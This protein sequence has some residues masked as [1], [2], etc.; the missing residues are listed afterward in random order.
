MSQRLNLHEVSREPADSVHS[1]LT[2]ACNSTCLSKNY[3]PQ[4]FT[5]PFFWSAATSVHENCTLGFACR[6][7]Y[8]DLHDISASWVP[9]RWYPHQ[10]LFYVQKLYERD[11][12]FLEGNTMRGR[13]QYN[14]LWC[15][16]WRRL[17]RIQMQI[18]GMWS[19]RLE[20][21]PKI[22]I[23]YA[24]SREIKWIEQPCRNKI[25]TTTVWVWGTPFQS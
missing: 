1:F 24:V 22:N 10:L 2:R 13:C 23:W 14:H 8:L 9:R 17:L 3:L 21:P 19:T 4:R 6:L 7:C 5:T 16:G 12:G 18:E 20:P 11:R 15:H 25:Q